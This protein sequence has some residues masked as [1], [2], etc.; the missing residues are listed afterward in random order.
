VHKVNTW[1]I[2]GLVANLG[3]MLEI[4][5]KKENFKLDPY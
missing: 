4:Y 1:K 3:H 2:M 5:I